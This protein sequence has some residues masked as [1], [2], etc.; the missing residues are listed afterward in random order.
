M[1]EMNW[2]DQ[3]NKTLADPNVI[4]LL[5]SFGAGLDPQG[6]GGALGG[7]TRNYVA[8]VAA[9]KRA[10]VQ[11]QAQQQYNAQTMEVLNEI[12]RRGGFT[13]PGQPGLTSAASDAS[14]GVTLKVDP[15]PTPGVGAPDTGYGTTMSPTPTLSPTAA[16]TAQQLVAQQMRPQGGGV[17]PGLDVPL[18][19]NLGPL[20][21]RTPP[22]QFDARDR[23]LPQGGGQQQVPSPVSPPAGAIPGTQPFGTSPITPLPPSTPGGQQRSMSAPGTSSVPAD[24]LDL[25][26]QIE[27]L[28]PFSYALQQLLAGR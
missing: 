14:G 1:G 15:S 26:R 19:P 27:D 24:P 7:A 21:P 8:A 3:T 22:G 17:Q 10:D 12:R 20:G 18:A 6:F 23:P 16:P 5:A 28:R 11:Q 13:P 2:L 4:N 25:Q 9:Q